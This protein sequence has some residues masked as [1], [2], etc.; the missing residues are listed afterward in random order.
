MQTEYEFSYEAALLPPLS[1]GAVQGGQRQV[2]QV[3]DGEVTGERIRGTLVGGADWALIGADGFVRLDVRSHIVTHDEAIIYFEY[4]GLLEMNA[5]FQ[6]ARAQG[7]ETQYG[8]HY[9]YTNP[10]L[11]TGDSRYAW[12]NTTFFVG[13]GRATKEG[14]AYRISRYL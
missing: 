2:F 8:D 1:V 12:V 10:R 3:S 6:N 4:T 11:E 9:F 13:Q 14:V 5:A 7:G